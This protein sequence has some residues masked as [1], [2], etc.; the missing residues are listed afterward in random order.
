MRLGRKRRHRD[1]LKTRRGCCHE[2]ERAEH[3]SEG[4][5][6]YQTLQRIPMNRDGKTPTEVG[7]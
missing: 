5:Q 3:F 2:T 6:Q 1:G 4:D 7:N